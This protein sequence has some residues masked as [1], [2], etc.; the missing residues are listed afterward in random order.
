MTITAVAVVCM[1]AL[2]L[3]AEESHIKAMHEAVIPVIEA[4]HG[5]TTAVFT[6]R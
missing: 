5:R 6:S 1:Y 2:V 4:L 3:G